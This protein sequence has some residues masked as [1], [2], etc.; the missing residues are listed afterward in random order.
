MP[1]IF[2]TEQFG[3]Q[4][5]KSEASE[6]LK[7]LVENLKVAIKESLPL[8]VDFG[9]AKC[10]D[11]FISDSFGALCRSEFN[12]IQ[13]L[14]HLDLVSNDPELIKNIQQVIGD[15]LGWPKYMD[16]YMNPARRPSSFRA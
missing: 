13:I 6:F 9:E 2:V 5:S 12:S 7:S 1:R 3:S 4:L 10:S 8:I 11:S 16:L 14:G 15:V